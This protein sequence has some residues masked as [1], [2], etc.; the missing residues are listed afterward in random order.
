MAFVAAFGM[1]LGLWLL[2]KALAPFFL[3]M[4]LAYLLA[5]AV[6]IL[7]RWMKRGLAVVLVVLGSVAGFVLAIRLAIPHFLEQMSRLADS[8]PAWKAAMDAKWNPWLQ[9]HPWVREKL[10][11]GLESLDSMTLV[12][13]VWGAG[14]DL[15]AGFL[16]AMTFL[17]VPVMVYYLLV[18]GPHLLNSVDDLIP[19][20]FRARIRLIVRTIHQRLGGYIRGQISVA[21]VMALLQSIAFQI[22]GVPYAWLLGL[23]AGVSNVVPYSPYLTALAPALVVAGLGGATW[24]DLLIIAVV[25]TA[26]QKAEALY[27]TPVWIGRASKLH[28]LEVLVAILCFGFAFGLL[29]LVFAVPMMIILKV[30]LG[31]LIEDYK[32]HPWFLKT[33]DHE[34]EA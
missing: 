15:V 7:S 30:I 10:Q 33:A 17:L 25:F 5:P 2:R 18:E 8:F 3:A 14:A 16:Q 12:K 11:H 27:F 13:S 28:P 9:A 20:R 21:L 19:P 31:T 4:V 1:I 34:K 29:G 22:V 6:T 32:N 23:I 24:P 26:V